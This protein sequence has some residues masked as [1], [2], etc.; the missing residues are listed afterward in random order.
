MVLS[1]YQFDV[2]Y[3]KGKL[4]VVVDAMSRVSAFC[5]R[6]DETGYDAIDGKRTRSIWHTTKTSSSRQSTTNGTSLNSQNR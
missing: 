1:E 3:R 4:N 5:S 2:Q 6:M